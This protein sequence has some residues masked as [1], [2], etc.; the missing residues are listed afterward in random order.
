MPQQLQQIAITQ[1]TKQSGKT[2]DY[3]VPKY[4]PKPKG[5]HIHNPTRDNLWNIID[6]NK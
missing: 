2:I 1:I 3:K 5:F 4:V 6:E